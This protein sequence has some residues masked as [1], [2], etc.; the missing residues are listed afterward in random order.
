MPI[1][2]Q[3]ICRHYKRVKFRWNQLCSHFSD[4]GPTLRGLEGGVVMADTV[5]I[6]NMVMNILNTK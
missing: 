3:T 1:L 2:W 6:V 5:Q 4:V